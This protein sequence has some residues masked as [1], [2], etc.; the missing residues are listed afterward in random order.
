MIDASQDGADNRRPG[1]RNACDFERTMHQQ[2]LPRGLA[3]VYTLAVVWLAGCANLREADFVAPVPPPS[4]EPIAGGRNGREHALQQQ[5]IGRTRAELIGSFGQPSMVMN[6]PGNRL[7]ESVI[8]VYRN[9]DSAGGC[10]DA[11]VVLRDSREHIWN[12]FCR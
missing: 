7:P 9:R 2:R 4:T 11:F 5:W 6:V 12:Y 8:L 10:V 1:M 3:A